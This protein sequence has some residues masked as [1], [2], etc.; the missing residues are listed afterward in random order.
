MTKAIVFLVLI[1]VF[2]VQH[3]LVKF[4]NHDMRWFLVNVKIES[5]SQE[6]HLGMA[7]LLFLT[8]LSYR[9]S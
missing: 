9:F 2:N 8:T 7:I 6:A 1:N 4:A 3:Q 5:L